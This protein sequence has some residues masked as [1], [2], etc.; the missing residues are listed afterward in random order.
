MGVGDVAVGIADV[1]RRRRVTRYVVLRQRTEDAIRTLRQRHTEIRRAATVQVGV[2]Q[3]PFRAGAQA[4]AEIDGETATVVIDMVTIRDTAILEHAVDT[5]RGR[6]VQAD[7]AV[8]RRAV[9]RRRTD[10]LVDAGARVQVRPLGRLV[11]Q[12]TDIAHAERLTRRSL[13]HFHAFGVEAVALVCAEVSQTIDID[14]ALGGKAA[15]AELVAVL[16]AVALTR[17]N[18]NTRHVLQDLLEG[19]GLLLLDDL[20]G[21]DVDRLGRFLDGLRQTRDPR[22]CVIGV[23]NTLARYR[24][25]RQHISVVGRS[26]RTLTFRRGLRMYDQRNS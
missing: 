20:L 11:D 1:G 8:D 25:R 18:R 26:S 7:I 6:I 5:Y 19:S 14:V 21:H 13:D 9:R 3:V 16:P 23:W 24:D 22:R 15:N 10:A 17:G 4:G 12:T 2:I